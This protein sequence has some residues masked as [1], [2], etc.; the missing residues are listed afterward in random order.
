[1][2]D[3]GGR[4]SESNFARILKFSDTFPS[5]VGLLIGQVVLLS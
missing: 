5:E 3:V 1:M 2:D 4:V